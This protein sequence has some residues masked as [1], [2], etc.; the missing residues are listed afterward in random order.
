V[1]WYLLSAVNF[2]QVSSILVE[3]NGKSTD[4]NGKVT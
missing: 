1:I 2:Y 3:S 4:I